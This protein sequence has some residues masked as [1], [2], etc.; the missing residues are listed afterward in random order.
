MKNKKKSYQNLWPYAIMYTMSLLVWVILATIPGIQWIIIG[1]IV[2]SSG[3]L[4]SAYLF[5]QAEE[6]NRN[7]IGRLKSKIEMLSKYKDLDDEY[8]KSYTRKVEQPTI[9][10][11][12]EVKTDKNGKIIAVKGKVWR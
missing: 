11:I 3:M 1:S 4:L 12:Y 5:Y 2:G 7:K 6:W 9:K 8:F 10:N